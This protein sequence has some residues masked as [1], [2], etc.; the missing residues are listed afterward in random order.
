MVLPR[1]RAEDRRTSIVSGVTTTA[2]LYTP[3]FN[4]TRKYPTPGSDWIDETAAAQRYDDGRELVAVDPTRVDGELHPA[5]SIGFG[6]GGAR[7]RFYTPG[8][9]IRRTITYDL[10]DG[11]YWRWTTTD[12]TYPD[13]TRAYRLG[14]AVSRVTSMFEPDGTGT[15]DLPRENER[16]TLED[17]PVHG[18]WMDRPRFGHWD[19]LVDPEYGIPSGRASSDARTGRPDVATDAPSTCGRRTSPD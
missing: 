16:A 15:V 6:A 8:G 4:T 12:Y 9:S 5:W 11:R 2:A 17:A 3:R 14:D 7:V 13:D 19:D 1:A 10:R 18:F